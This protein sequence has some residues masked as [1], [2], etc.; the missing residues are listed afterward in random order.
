[1]RPAGFD[2]DLLA[3]EVTAGMDAERNSFFLACTVYVG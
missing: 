3:F 2:P 1:M